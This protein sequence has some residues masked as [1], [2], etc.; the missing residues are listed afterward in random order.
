MKD[1]WF[2]GLLFVGTVLGMEAWAWF[3][4][5][6]L[7]HG[8]LWFLHKSHHQKAPTWWEWNDLVAVLYGLISTALVMY[9]IHYGSPVKYI[10]FGIGVYGVLYFILHD[11]IIHRRI[12]TRWDPQNPYLVRLI[13]A[14]RAHHRHIHQAD[15]EAFG[16]LYAIRK[17]AVDKKKLK[18]VS[19][20]QVQEGSS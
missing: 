12:K 20:R 5:K 1:A 10:G 9:G 8:P 11:V 13:R 15:S 7:L 6:Y 16:F 17:Y 14:H 18:A 2:N 3:S 19:A 4:H